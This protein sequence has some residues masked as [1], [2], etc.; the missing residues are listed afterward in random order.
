MLTRTQAPAPLALEWK[1]RAWAYGGVAGVGLI[2]AFA[3]SL[4]LDQ[5]EALRRHVARESA[6]IAWLVFL[7]SEA[8]RHGLEEAIRAFPGIQTIRFVSKDEALRDF[9]KD[10]V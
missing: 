5:R 1:T 7:N 8:D 9:Q 3:L 2:V 10:A 4:F 6:D